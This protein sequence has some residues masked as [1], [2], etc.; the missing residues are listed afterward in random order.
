MFVVVFAAVPFI[1]ATCRTKEFKYYK[2]L[3]MTIMRKIVGEIKAKLRKKKPDE[4]LIRDT[5]KDNAN[6]EKSNKIVA[7]DDKDY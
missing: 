1:L 4:K 3:A 6:E 7:H 2:N 5:N